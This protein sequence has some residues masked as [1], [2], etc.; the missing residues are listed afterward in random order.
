MTGTLGQ[1]PSGEAEASHAPAPVGPQIESGRLDEVEIAKAVCETPPLVASSSDAVNVADV[2]ADGTEEVLLVDD[3]MALVVM[4]VDGDP[5]DACAWGAVLHR[6]A[7]VTDPVASLYDRPALP[8]WSSG[9][10]PE[11][12]H[13]SVLP[14]GRSMRIDVAARPAHDDPGPASGVYGYVFFSFLVTWDEAPLLAAAAP[15]SADPE[16]VESVVYWAARSGSG[17]L[18]EV[19]LTW[20]VHEGRVPLDAFFERVPDGFAGEKDRTW[21]GWAGWVGHLVQAESPDLATLTAV[22]KRLAEFFPVGRSEDLSSALRSLAL[23]A[24]ERLA[25]DGQYQAAHD[26]ALD[27]GIMS[28]GFDD[29]DLEKLRLTLIAQLPGLVTGGWQASVLTLATDGEVDE[30]IWHVD[31]RLLVHDEGGWKILADGQLAVPGE[32]DLDLALSQAMP[33]WKKAG[34]R[35]TTS[36]ALT[37]PAVDCPEGSPEV[38]GRLDVCKKKSPGQCNSHLFVPSSGAPF[39]WTAADA[40]AGLEAFDLVAFGPKDTVIVARRGTITKLTLNPQPGKPKKGQAPDACGTVLVDTFAKVESFPDLSWFLD[41]VV[42]SPYSA[43]GMGYLY[44]AEGGVWLASLQP[45]VPDVLVVPMTQDVARAVWAPDGRHIAIT[46]AQGRLHVASVSPPG[47]PAV[48]F[49]ESEID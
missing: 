5:A 24:V 28:Q 42:S 2:D 18:D 10:V 3:D 43:D 37:V 27:A 49:D 15:A 16:E 19:R 26:L 32:E 48:T 45:G 44:G 33:E 36:F 30:L 6:V 31:G 8:A 12:V 47:L 25:G 34:F 7:L 20:S 29:P 11:R 21:S 4:S 23:V 14:D 38:F 35:W 39:P 17:H 41:L 40:P 9:A 22:R 13:M 1:G 46:D